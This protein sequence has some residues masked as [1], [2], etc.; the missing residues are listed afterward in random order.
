MLTKRISGAISSWET[1]DNT[2]VQS[3][4]A[5][6]E[7]VRARKVFVHPMVL[8]SIVDGFERRSEDAKRVIGTLL[9]SVDKTSVEIRSCFGVP[10]NESEDEVCSITKF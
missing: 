3:N 9:G 4:M 6:S 5:A 10:H 7:S 2:C 8:F 1:G